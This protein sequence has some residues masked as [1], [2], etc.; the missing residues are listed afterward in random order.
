MTADSQTPEGG[1][2]A[3]PFDITEFF[4]DSMVSEF[5]CGRSMLAVLAAPNPKPKVREDDLLLLN[6]DFSESDDPPSSE[7]ES[8]E[9]S[10]EP[11]P[12]RTPSPP[13]VELESPSPKEKTPEPPSEPD[14][15]VPELP[16]SPVIEITYQSPSPRSKTMAKI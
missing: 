16:E 9:S 10:K 7:P 6:D 12:R 14:T 4:K 15:A 5:I 11:T 2:V 1:R 13:I 8:I 3:R